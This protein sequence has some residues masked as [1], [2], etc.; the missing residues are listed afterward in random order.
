MTKFVTRK[1]MENEE[2][3]QKTA[4]ASV[5]KIKPYFEMYGSQNVYNS[6]ESGFQL[7]THSGRTLADGGSKE[8]SYIVQSIT[9]TTHSYTIQPTI[10]ADAKLL[11]PLFIVYKE[12]SGT[13][14]SR[15]QKNLFRPSNIYVTASKSEKLTFEHFKIWLEEVFFPH[16]GPKNLL[17]IDSWSGH[18]SRVVEEVTPRNKELLTMLIPKRTTGKI[19]PLDVYGFRIWKNIYPSFF[20]YGRS[21]ES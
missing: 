7:Q 15:V 10:S 6:D 8:V 5:Q 4:H 16:V 2:D 19:H 21:L 1:T 13:F 14:G 11:S 20:R 9:S 17:L 3:L 18:C 12:P